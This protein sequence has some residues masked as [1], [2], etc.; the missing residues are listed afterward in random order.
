MHDLLKFISK[1]AKINEATPLIAYYA[2]YSTCGT[3]EEHTLVEEIRKEYSYR[4]LYVREL[5][6]G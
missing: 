4:T 1:R 2:S 5:L 6:K 3:V